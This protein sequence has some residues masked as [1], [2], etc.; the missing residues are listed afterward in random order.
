[1]FLLHNFD[2][3]SVSMYSHPAATCFNRYAVTTRLILYTRFQSSA[4]KQMRTA[5]FWV[6][7]RRVVAVSH[8]HFRTTSR[9]HLQVSRIQ[10]ELFFLFGFLKMAPIR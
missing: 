2:N 6:I 3:G 7:T 9:S 8:R 1:M 5:L 4:A 10:R